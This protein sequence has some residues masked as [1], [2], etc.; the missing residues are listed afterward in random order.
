MGTFEVILMV[1]FLRYCEFSLFMLEVLRFMILDVLIM[2]CRH[3]SQRGNLS[4]L[5]PHFAVACILLLYII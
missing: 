5:G 3:P 1:R 2:T 4:P